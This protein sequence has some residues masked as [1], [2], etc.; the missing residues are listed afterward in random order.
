RGSLFALA[1]S[2]AAMLPSPWST[3]DEPI[4]PIPSYDSFVAPLVENYCA[5]CHADSE[6]EGGLSFDKLDGGENFQKQRAEWQEVARRL[7]DGTMPPADADPIAI[8]ERDAWLA[9]ID[10]RLAEF[11]CSG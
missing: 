7:R 5:A 3:A 11:D 10:A 4:R 9:W 8:D 6:A 1:A 2:L